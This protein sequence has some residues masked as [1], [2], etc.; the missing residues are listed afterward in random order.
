M[1]VLENGENLYRSGG[2]ARMTPAS[3][4]HDNSRIFGKLISIEPDDDCQIAEIV[5]IK[6]DRVAI[7]L[8][9]DLS[10]YIGQRI[11]MAYILGKYYVRRAEDD[12]DT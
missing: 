7:P 11:G 1:R 2:A 10:A 12:N 9:L 4:L 6:T 5:Q 8:D 3:P